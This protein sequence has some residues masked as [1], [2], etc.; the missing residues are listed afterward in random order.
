LGFTDLKKIL[1]VVIRWWDYD[2]P[3]IIYFL[4][5]LSLIQLRI[6]CSGRI[7]PMREI[8]YSGMGYSGI[9]YSGIGYYGIDYS[10]ITLLSTKA[11]GK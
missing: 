6:E 1:T 9:G 3:K 8:H 10:R 7:F 11:D 5:G 4:N 2:A